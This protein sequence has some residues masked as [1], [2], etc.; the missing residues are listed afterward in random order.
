M[1]KY[2]REKINDLLRDEVGKILLRELDLEVEALVTVTRA[3]VSED[4]QHVKVY[5]SVFPSK[6]VGEVMEQIKKQIYFFQQILNDKLR[7]RPIPKIFFVTDRT[8]EKAAKVE[9][10]I[11]KTEK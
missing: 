3:I 7:M 2:R 8:E 4:L 1:S 10:I 6:F 5:L 9:K 11:E